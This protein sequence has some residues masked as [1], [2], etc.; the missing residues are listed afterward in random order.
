MRNGKLRKFVYWSV[1][2]TTP[3]GGYFR[4]SWGEET[5]KLRIRI[6]VGKQCLSH[7]DTVRVHVVGTHSRPYPQVAG[8]RRVQP[9]LILFSSRAS[10][11]F[12]GG[13][14]K[15]QVDRSRSVQKKLKTT[16][17]TVPFSVSQIVPEKPETCFQPTDK[18]V[19]LS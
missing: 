16:I 3:H 18:N 15:Q 12:A 8:E 13:P 19:C 11:G 14:V 9:F 2:T 1:D 5:G 10:L 6:I 4:A 7:R 17:T